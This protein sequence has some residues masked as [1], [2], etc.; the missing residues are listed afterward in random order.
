MAARRRDVDRA[1]VART[2]CRAG[3]A[4]APHG[5]VGRAGLRVHLDVETTNR[6][7][8]RLYERLGFVATGETRPLRDGSPYHVERM[9]LRP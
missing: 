2:R 5:L 4:R 3:G 9:V 7:A 8:R 6:G 1:G